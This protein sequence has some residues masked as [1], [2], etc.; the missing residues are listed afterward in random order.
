MT[1]H[2]PRNG[3]TRPFDDDDNDLPGDD[4]D[5]VTEAAGATGDDDALPEIPSAL[6]PPAPPQELP[7]A[8]DRPRRSPSRG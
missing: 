5:E 2:P 1:T 7:A 3:S 6:D 8:A 4:A